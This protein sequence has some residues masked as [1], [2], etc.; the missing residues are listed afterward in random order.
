MNERAGRA[1]YYRGTG[2]GGGAVY[3][4]G[5]IGALVYYVQEADGF[6]SSPTA[7]PARHWWRGIGGAALVARH[8][9]RG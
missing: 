8:W 1:R 5:P 6:W 3:G 9:W 7:L 4:L 2:G